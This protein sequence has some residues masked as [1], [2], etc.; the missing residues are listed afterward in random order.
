MNTQNLME[1]VIELEWEMFSTVRNAGRRAECQT[2]KPTFSAMRASQLSDWPEALL[3]SY[4]DDLA[5][6]KRSERNL[7]TEKYAWMMESTFPEEFKRMV[8]LLP[9]VEPEAMRQI[10]AI[11]A[12]HVAWKIAVSE[13]YPK[14]GQ[15]GRPVC[16]FEDTPSDTSFETYLRGELKTY[17]PRTVSELH[18]HTLDLKARGQNGVERELLRQVHWYG[19]QTLEEAET[20][21]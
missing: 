7:M 8:H 3:S 12:I 21:Q 19:Y 20:K 1:N 9:K 11:V 10:D 16:S 14:I 6:A 15:K 5:E 4:R 17:S 2:N 18:K 13:K